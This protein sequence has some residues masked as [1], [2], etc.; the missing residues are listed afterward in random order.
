MR[1][2]EAGIKREPGCGFKLILNK[3]CRLAPSRVVGF[4]KR[5]ALAIGLRL[6]VADKIKG[7][8]ILLREAVES[9]AQIVPL[10]NPGQC[11]LASGVI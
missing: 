7:L 11:G 4:G 2:A 10:R 1:L 6:V 3:N 8:L 9:P 5:G